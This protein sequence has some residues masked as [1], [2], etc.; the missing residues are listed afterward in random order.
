[1]VIRTFVSHD[2]LGKVVCAPIDVFINQQNVLQPDIV[3]VAN[4]QLHQIKE[5]GIHGAP[6][7]VIEILSPSTAYYDTKTKKQIYEAAG[8]KE[9][10][11]VDPE[12]GEA[13]G[14]ELKNGKF[15]EFY[16]SKHKIEFKCLKLEI[17]FLEY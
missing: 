4:N 7:L 17:D 5:D 13:I 8:V 15:E 2:E 9:F 14:F 16:N 3:F 6:T 11:I 10:W 12:D 1:M